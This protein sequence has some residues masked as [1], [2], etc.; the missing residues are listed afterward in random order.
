MYLNSGLL[1][2]WNEHCRRLIFIIPRSQVGEVKL[3]YVGISHYKGIY[4]FFSSK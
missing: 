3:V 4:Y 1:K 2:T